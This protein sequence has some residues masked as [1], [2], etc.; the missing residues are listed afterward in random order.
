MVEY[1][2]KIPW[3]T[4]EKNQQ[5]SESQHLEKLSLPVVEFIKHK[6]IQKHATSNSGVQYIHQ[7]DI[8]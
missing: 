2:L 4:I 5:T 6:P 8:Q 7:R 1:P 3:F